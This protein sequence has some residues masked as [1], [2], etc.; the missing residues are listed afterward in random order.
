MFPGIKN[1]RQQKIF[2]TFNGSAPVFALSNHITCI[3][4]ETDVTVNL[5][6]LKPDKIPFLVLLFLIILILFFRIISCLSHLSVTAPDTTEAAVQ[7]KLT[8]RGKDP[9]NKM[10]NVQLKKVHVYHYLL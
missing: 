6:F 7:A 2:K 10:L 1:Q 5:N 4:T 3:L 8:C 9:I